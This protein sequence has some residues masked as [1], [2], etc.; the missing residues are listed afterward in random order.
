MMNKVTK[1]LRKREWSM[2]NGQCPDCGGVPERWH[3]HPLHM[4]TNTIGHEAE[5]DLAESLA[6]CGEKPLMKGE[7]R[8]DKQ[9][10]NYISEDGFLGTR[11]KTEHGCQ[12]YKAAS[13]EFQKHLD[14]AIFSGMSE[15]PN[16]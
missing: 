16:V 12:R 3:G 9:F 7:F 2:G 6:A 14:E 5:C 10:E 8:S 4:T 15:R 11:P 1:Y 13:E